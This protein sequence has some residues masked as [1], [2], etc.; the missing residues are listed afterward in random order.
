P[1]WRWSHY[2]CARLRESDP[3]RWRRIA[4]GCA[5][6]DPSNGGMDFMVQQRAW[7]SSIWYL[8]GGPVT[9]QATALTLRDDTAS[10]EPSRRRLVCRSRPRADTSDHRIAV[11][12]PGS[13][14]DPT[15]SGLGGG[16]TL[17]VFNPESGEAFT[18]A[19]PAARWKL[20]GRSGY[21]FDDPGGAVRKVVVSRDRLSVTG[22]GSG[23]GYTLDEPSPGAGAVRRQ[24][25]AA[26]PWRSEARARP[27]G[28][29][30]TTARSDTIDR[31][32]GRART[33]PPDQC[34]V[35]DAEPPVRRG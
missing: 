7:T 28:K 18:A 1:T 15:V 12:R 31:F 20:R 8:P 17:T 3:D 11:P 10:G 14:G 24:P 25:G 5:S 21:V 23:F 13:I 22:G 27:S 26:Q 33:P 2:D 35:V 34:P 9:V 6:D 4:P 16:G 29:P 30:P 32:I 19:L